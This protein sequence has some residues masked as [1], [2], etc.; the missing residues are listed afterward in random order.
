MLKLHWYVFH[1]VITEIK[2]VRL[3]QT[4]I[5][6]L[7]ESFEV[8]WLRL[9]NY[10]TLNYVSNSKLFEASQFKW[11]LL[12][13]TDHMEFL[14]HHSTHL[15]FIITLKLTVNIFRH[16]ESVF[17]HNGDLKTEQVTQCTVISYSLQ[18]TVI[19]FYTWKCKNANY[20]TVF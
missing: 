2:A 10:L 12:W 18:L 4:E 20:H 11:F 6:P 7:L 5:N 9:L 16:L 1:T 3:Q 17:F 13:S 19:I 14:T 8:K 15:H